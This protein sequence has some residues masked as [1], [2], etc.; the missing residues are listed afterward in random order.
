VQ[1]LTTLVSG[2]VGLQFYL[3]IVVRIQFV[4][5]TSILLGHCIVC[6][7]M[8]RKEGCADLSARLLEEMTFWNK[9]QLPMGAFQYDPATKR[10]SPEKKSSEPLTPKE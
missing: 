4:V 6:F 8:T 3:K 9:L 2:R 5:V 7:K 1:Q 10:Q